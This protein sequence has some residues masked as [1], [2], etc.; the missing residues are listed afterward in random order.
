MII[1]KFVDCVILG[2][3]YVFNGTKLK[4]DGKTHKTRSDQ[5]QQQQR[6][7]QIEYANR[8]IIGIH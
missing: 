2:G 5:Q 1:Y 6:A 8:R 4:T 3:G 7:H